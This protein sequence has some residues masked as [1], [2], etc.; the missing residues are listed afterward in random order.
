MTISPELQALIGALRQEVA[1]LRSEVGALRQESAG[2]LPV[3]KIRLPS[4]E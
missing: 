2:L 3:D 4:M 1:E